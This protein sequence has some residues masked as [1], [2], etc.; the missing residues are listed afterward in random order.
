VTERTKD[1]NTTEDTSQE[2]DT[3]F[4]DTND[5]AARTMIARQPS[6]E[7]AAA[8]SKRFDN[9]SSWIM[10]SDLILESMKHN[11]QSAKHSVQTISKKAQHIIV[12]SK[13]A[14]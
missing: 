5:Q 6:D 8:L 13:P 14:R 7:A 3:S 12:N 9:Y 10:N 2:T 1:E 4:V 11:V